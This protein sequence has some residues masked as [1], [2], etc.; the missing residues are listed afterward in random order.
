[1]GAIKTIYRIMKA[2]LLSLFVLSCSMD[3]PD[4][5]RELSPDYNRALQYLREHRSQIDRKISRSSSARGIMI[6]VVFP[7]IIRYSLVRD[8]I[9]TKSLELGYVHKGK[10]FVDFSIGRFQMKPSF[11]EN[12]ERVLHS[13]PGLSKRH[14]GLAQ[15]EGKSTQAARKKRLQR[16]KKLNGQLTY[17]MA[18]YDV[19]RERFPGLKTQPLPYQVQF[20]AA[21]YNHG[22]MSDRQEVEKWMDRACYPYGTGVPGKQY[23]YSRVA[24][25]FWNHHYK[26]IFENS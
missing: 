20:F 9:E 26:K 12:L 5:Q 18:F 2:F 21:A 8:L 23:S 6:S 10:D 24:L 15:N 14:D 1:M 25:Y 3:F 19:V 16:L 11:A 13:S 7:E 22:F 4:Y 17:L